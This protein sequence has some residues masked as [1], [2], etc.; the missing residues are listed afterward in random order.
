MWYLK[1]IGIQIIL[2]LTVMFSYAQSP[3]DLYLDD[4]EFDNYSDSV[5]LLKE[6]TGGFFLHSAGWGLEFR[7]GKNVN[8]FKKRMFEVDFTEMNSARC[9]W[10]CFGSRGRSS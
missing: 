3:D 7:K 1:F 6:V 9:F 4:F 2:L 5:L 8:A 10:D